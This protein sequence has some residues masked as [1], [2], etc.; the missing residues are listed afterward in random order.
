VFFGVCS[1]SGTPQ[2]STQQKSV[3]NT[4]IDI[5]LTLLKIKVESA[6]SYDIQ[7]KKI[8][9]EKGGKHH[10]EYEVQS[11]GFRKTNSQL[12][13]ELSTMSNISVVAQTSLS[14][15]D[16][17]SVG[18]RL[19]RSIYY[20][21]SINESMV[22]GKRKTTMEAESVE[23]GEKISITPKIMSNN[24]ISFTLN[25]NISYINEVITQKNGTQ[26]PSVYSCNIAW[27]NLPLVSN[28]DTLL[29]PVCSFTNKDQYYLLI[30]PRIEK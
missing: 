7:W 20:M 11:F 13:G 5:D 8:F 28:G 10:N 18:F 2:Q 3:N 24:K 23:V 16:G 9:Q 1:A 29:Y 21:G 27:L 19:T 22:K 14:T 26:L 4:N 30:S 6:E 12:I 17:E 15:F 25:S